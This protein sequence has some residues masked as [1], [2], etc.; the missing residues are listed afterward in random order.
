M[1]TIPF[2]FFR[3]SNFGEKR[4]LYRRHRALKTHF[5]SFV[6]HCS[7]GYVANHPE[8]GWLAQKSV[9]RK[10]IP[11]HTILPQTQDISNLLGDC[12][13]V[14]SN[15]VDARSLLKVNCRSTSEQFAARSV[16]LAN[17]S[18]A[19]RRHCVN[20]VELEF[21]LFLENFARLFVENANHR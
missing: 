7:V 1:F 21:I 17:A 6:R 15:A 5:G 4:L 12:G 18:T 11:N 3:A 19:S 14:Y 13:K 20:F 10:N 9:S 2:S 16:P 8:S